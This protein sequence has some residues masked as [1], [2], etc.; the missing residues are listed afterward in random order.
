AVGEAFGFLYLTY[1][2][3]NVVRDEKAIAGVSSSQMFTELFNKQHIVDAIGSAFKKR[4]GNDRIK[5]LALL[6]CHALVMAP[7]M[8]EQAVIFLFAKYKFNWDAGAFAAF[9]TYR[10]ISGFLG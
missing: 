3:P 2:L 10:M 4:P 9:M 1:G 6:L 5:L 8:G 7:M